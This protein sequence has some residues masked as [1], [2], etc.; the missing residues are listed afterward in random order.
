MARRGTVCLC[1]TAT[2][3]KSKCTRV[4][5]KRP[6]VHGR[7]AVNWPTNGAAGDRVTCLV[8]KTSDGMFRAFGNPPIV[9]G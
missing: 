2:G 4:T 3:L 1:P 6:N 8:G 7:L 5:R 9:H